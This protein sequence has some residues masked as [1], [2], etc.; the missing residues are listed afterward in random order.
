MLNAEKRNFVI[1]FSC[2]GCWLTAK[3]NRKYSGRRTRHICDE[4]Q[5]HFRLDNGHKAAE[6]EDDSSSFVLRNDKSGKSQGKGSYRRSRSGIIVQRQTANQQRIK[7]DFNKRDSVLSCIFFCCYFLFLAPSRRFINIFPNGE[8]E[9]QEKQQKEKCNQ[10]PAE[11][12]ILV[13]TGETK[14]KYANY[15]QDTAVS[16]S[17]FPI[18]FRTLKISSLFRPLNLMKK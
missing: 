1:C 2:C 17:H 8:K 12:E 7:F 13:L 14:E 6:S 11:H 4:I 9:K 15:G 10:R 3:V 16:L 5:C 18:P